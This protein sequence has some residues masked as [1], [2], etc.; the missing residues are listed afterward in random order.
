MQQTFQKYYPHDNVN[1]YGTTQTDH[2]S[3]YFN[4]Y[5]PL[6]PI[7][8]R[9]KRPFFW[10]A[11][12]EKWNHDKEFS[13]HLL[14]KLTLRKPSNSLSHTQMSIEWV[15]TKQKML[16]KSVVKKR[17]VL[18]LTLQSHQTVYRASIQKGKK[19]SEKSVSKNV[20]FWSW[21]WNHRATLAE[22]KNLFLCTAV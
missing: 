12:H 20:L 8:T 18:K 15:Y 16:W 22:K 5:L 10:F 7:I 11:K 19:C 13:V 3:T 6:Y 2:F 14:L 21:L 9:S 4:A 1:T 17:F